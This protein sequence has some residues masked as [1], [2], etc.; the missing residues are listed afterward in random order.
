[1]AASGGCV[2]EPRKLRPLPKCQCC[3]Q[4]QQGG[5]QQPPV[6]S[7]L[8]AGGLSLF[9]AQLEYLLLG[10]CVAMNRFGRL[11]WMPGRAK[12]WIGMG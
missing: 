11:T 12:V 8:L 9:P 6:Q 10:L 1:M 7:L 2:E 4:W 5:H 3:C